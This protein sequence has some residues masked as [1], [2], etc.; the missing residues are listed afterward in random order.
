MTSRG[1]LQQQRASL[2]SGQSD[3]PALM[4]DVQG[5][6]FSYL[7]PSSLLNVE[8]ASREFHTVIHSRRLWYHL[9]QQ[10]CL[11]PFGSD[12]EEWR[13][14]PGH[15]H[16]SDWKR[17]FFQYGREI[18]RPTCVLRRSPIS[19]RYIW[20]VTGLGDKLR[21]PL[22]IHD[23]KP[24]TISFAEET[25]S[26]DTTRRVSTSWKLLVQRH[27]RDGSVQ[28]GAFLQQDRVE[29]ANVR[30]DSVHCYFAIAMLDMAGKPIASHRIE[31]RFHFGSS[32]TCGW[33]FPANRLADAGMPPLKEGLVMELDV[34]VF[35]SE[36]SNVGPLYQLITAEHTEPDLKRVVVQCLGE[37]VTHRARNPWR[38]K[39]C[40]QTRNGGPVT[41]VDM[42][43]NPRTGV[44]LKTAI[45]G[46]LWNILDTS[47]MY[48]DA[49]LLERV[50]DSACAS[51]A[52]FFVVP[53]NDQPDPEKRC[54]DFL[55]DG[56][57]RL[58]AS[59][60]YARC[61]A[62]RRRRGLPVWGRPPFC[63]LHLSEEGVPDAD[64]YRVVFRMPETPASDD[65]APPV[66]SDADQAVRLAN[67]LCGLIWNIPICDKYRSL[68]ANH[69][70]FFP[71]LAAV[72][73]QPAL[74][75]SH[76]SCLHVLTTLKLHGCFPDEPEFKE[77][78]RAYLVQYLDA[79][80][81]DK[82]H[83]DIGVALCLR[84]VAD[85][86]V[87]L[88]RSKDLDCIAFGKWAITVFYCNRTDIYSW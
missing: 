78:F 26:G 45:A 82:D 57:A 4:R 7:P 86:F 11:R 19:G 14:P 24:F 84:D 40:I 36:L 87:P 54:C 63:G 70:A 62:T 49:R 83:R 61:T 72:L 41:L 65:A 6:V 53:D 67:S 88:L 46:C 12:E 8:L 39:R 42:L 60:F 68:L 20:R 16:P 31:K 73:S 66:G 25:Q 38:A 5:I 85:F 13:M 74:H 43:Q 34:T 21:E 3:R 35:P 44:P 55:L 76:F 28:I 37:F 48:I 29:I 15:C 77:S 79:Y 47:C 59:R 17:F 22:S 2:W 81:T 32:N 9:F 50:V 80:D 75:R 56:A 64:P 58:T 52:E 27:V 51:L 69:W 30:A 71:S 18:D 10:R 23:S 1:G 33:L